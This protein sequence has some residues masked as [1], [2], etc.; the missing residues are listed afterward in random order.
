MKLTVDRFGKEEWKQFS[1][2]AHLVC[3]GAHKPAEWDRIDFA[4]MVRSDEAPLGY[5]TCRET[6]A[7]SVYWQFGGAFPSSRGTVLSWL[8]YNEFVNYCRGKYRSITTMIENVNTP[9]LRMA[10]KVGFLIIGSRAIGGRIYLEHLL[11]FSDA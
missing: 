1:E 3:F 4:L 5:V 10:M 7:D 6:S 2:K 11:E 8:S 9:M